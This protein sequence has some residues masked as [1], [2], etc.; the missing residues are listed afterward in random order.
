M[1]KSFMKTSPA[2]KKDASVAK[3]KKV[4]LHKAEAAPT[5]YASGGVVRGAGAALRGKKYQSC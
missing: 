2:M 3:T 4:P 1:A 5:G